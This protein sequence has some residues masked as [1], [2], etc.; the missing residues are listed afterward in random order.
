M[1][2]LIY[3]NGKYK[4]TILRNQPIAICKYEKKLRIA[5][6]NYNPNKFKLEKKK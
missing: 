4:E 3:V 6:N 1:Y 2:D 5:T